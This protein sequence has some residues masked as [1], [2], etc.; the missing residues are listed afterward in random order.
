MYSAVPWR[1]GQSHYMHNSR[2]I[3]RISECAVRPTVE[4]HIALF[5]RGMAETG[6]VEG[7]D[8][9]IEFSFA[10]G[11]YDRLPA[12]ATAL[13]ARPVDLIVAQSPPAALAAKAA[14][15]TICIVFAAGIDA[16]A[17][18]LVASFNRP[19]GNATGM[20]LVPGPLV[21]KRL[22]LVES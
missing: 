14:T 20:V 11:Q 5:R 9:V 22:E 15:S 8:A 16:V 2:K 10:N 19:G 3:D 4:P 17:A 1:P 21:Q 12:M 18:G 13:I 6:I 7:R